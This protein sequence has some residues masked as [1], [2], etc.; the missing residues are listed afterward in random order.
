MGFMWSEAGQGVEAMGRHRS[1][2]YIAAMAPFSLKD[3]EICMSGE[4]V[5]GGFKEPNPTLQDQA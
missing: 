3:P 5:T 1:Q 2:L 4:G